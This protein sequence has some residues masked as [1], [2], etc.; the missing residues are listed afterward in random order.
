MDIIEDW[1]LELKKVAI[2]HLTTGN[3]KGIIKD[4]TLVGDQL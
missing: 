1:P 4:C 3:A 2:D